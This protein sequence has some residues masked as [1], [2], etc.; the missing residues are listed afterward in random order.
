MTGKLIWRIEGGPP[1]PEASTPPEPEAPPPPA[2]RR[3]APGFLSRRGYLW[4]L[5][6]AMAVGFAF[7]RWTELEARPY[8]AVR[9]SLELS[10]WALARADLD[11]AAR[12]LD[13][14]SP[15]AWREAELARQASATSLP[16][17]DALQDLELVA[18]DLVRVQLADPADP[19][20]RETRFYRRHGTRWL[21]A[22]PLDPASPGSGS[23]P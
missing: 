10:R 11:L 19:E 20:D 6:A 5:L 14:L 15:A 9:D 22:A 23:Q 3:T 17:P 12:A 8:L 18:E 21:Q 7:G 1:G 4:V 13:P 16:G 2:R